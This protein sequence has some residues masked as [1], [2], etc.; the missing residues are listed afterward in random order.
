MSD[1]QNWHNPDYAVSRTLG[2]AS[3]GVILPLVLL[4]LLSFGVS[5]GARD[6]ADGHPYTFIWAGGAFALALINAK[7]AGSNLD[8][9]K[10]NR[11]AW[12]VLSALAIV[13]AAPGL[14]AP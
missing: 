4:C 13:A 7:V 1:L 5:T 10:R 8:N 11:T 12:L 2:C 14:W 6:V 9:P 3:L